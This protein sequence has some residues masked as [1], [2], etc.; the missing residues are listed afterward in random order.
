[1]ISELLYYIFIF[2][3]EQ[4]LDVV[5]HNILKVI[6]S[7][8]TSIIVLSLIVNLFLLKIFLYTDKKAQEESELKK[9]LD[10]RIKSWKSVYKR[11]KL[12]AFTQTLYRQHNYHPIYALRSLGG[13][14]LQIPFF[15][16]M[17]EI[18]N[19]ATYLQYV[20]FLWIDDLSK[21]DSITLFDI[22]IHVLPILMTAFTLINVFYS[23]EEKSARIQ[24]SLIALLF[25]VLLYNMPSA[26]VLYWTC[27]MGFALFKEIFKRYRNKRHQTTENDTNKNIP[28]ETIVASKTISAYGYIYHK[29]T[30][31]NNTTNIQTHKNASKITN[32][33]SVTLAC[34]DT[35]LI[36]R[37]DSYVL[38]RYIIIS[39][40]FMICVSNPY[41]LYVTDLNAFELE[42]VIPTLAT[43][44]GFFILISFILIYFI[45]FFKHNNKILSF[46]LWLI[47]WILLALTLL[48]VIYSFILSGDY[49]VMSHFFFEKSIEVTNKQELIDGIM[50]ASCLTIALLLLRCTNYIIQACKILFVVLVVNAMSSLIVAI[51][52]VLEKNEVQNQ[53]PTP[54]TKKTQILDFA[55]QHKNI[56]VLILDRSDGYVVHELFKQDKHLKT[57]F[58]G[59]IDFT[60]ALSTS[61][62]TLP[63][64][65]SVIAGEYYTALNI[66]SRNISDGLA[67]EIARGY[68][69]TLNA[70]ENAGYAVSSILDFPT[71]SV[72]LYP[73]I[74]NTSTN[75]FDTVELQ[76]LYVEKYLGG[77]KASEIPLKQLISYGLFRSTTYVIRKSVYH[78]GL[79]LF[80][81]QGPAN[82]RSLKGVAEIRILAE[83][84]TANATK[85]TFKFIHNSITHSPYGLDN[86]CTINPNKAVS[87]QDNIYGIPAGHYNSESCA[88]QWVAKMLERLKKLGVYDNTEIFITA[89]HGAQSK[90]LPVKTNFHIPLFYKPMYAKGEMKKDA[91]IIT[92][93]DI[94][95]LFCNNIKRSCP[96][97]TPITLGSI[98]HR[99][100]IRM[101]ISNGWNLNDQ[102]PNSFKIS[103]LYIFDGSDIYDKK[104]WHVHKE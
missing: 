29:N 68:A 87:P 104:A 7:Y 56:L 54:T 92:N 43:L 83:N 57:S 77:V 71:D 101:M 38:I 90:F 35:H 18:I 24:G 27:N 47:S 32:R 85:P 99:R 98:P 96:N 95:A 53:I 73:L 61:G 13:L 44:F 80:N 45:G 100:N 79:W 51:N 81:S 28:L 78:H 52:H 94:P 34:Q 9:K 22:Q 26:L 48:G 103:R 69:G 84:T 49:G 58:E 72:H 2:P 89:D 55:K 63:T 10:K 97:I 15:F 76:N 17:Y 3:L 62:L 1:M 40:S 39:L 30:L 37:Q 46:T 50:I 14:A 4:V 74:T 19:N 75:I 5:L 59:F 31:K 91:R 64:L 33:K 41:A 8:G 12:Y 11:A 93:Y 23:S 67:N 88:W 42:M 102:N 6:P 16:A 70:F 20:S 36:P 60:N 21:P 82:I 86:T 25:L 65:T 66:N